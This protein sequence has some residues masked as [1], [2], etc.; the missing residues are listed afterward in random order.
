MPSTDR[1]GWWSLVLCVPGLLAGGCLRLVREPPPYTQG[2]V[3]VMSQPCQRP[4]FGGEEDVHDGAECMVFYIVQ[5]FKV[6]CYYLGLVPKQRLINF[7][8]CSVV[9]QQ[10]RR[11]EECSAAKPRRTTDRCQWHY[12]S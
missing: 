6:K 3:S 7:N 8:N 2:Q 9:P 5:H 12:V 10:Y 4:K 11:G 1:S